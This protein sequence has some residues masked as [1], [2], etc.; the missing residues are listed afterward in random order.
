MSKYAEDLQYE[1]YELTKKPPPEP[2]APANN[3][4]ILPLKNLKKE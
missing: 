2:P 4:K 3:Y 1:K